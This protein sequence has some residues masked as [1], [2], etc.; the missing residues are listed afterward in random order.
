[1]LLIEGIVLGHRISPTS[2]KVDLAKIEVIS[3]LPIPKTQKDVH[4]FL[5]AC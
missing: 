5:G 3:N 2:I 4:S 1:M